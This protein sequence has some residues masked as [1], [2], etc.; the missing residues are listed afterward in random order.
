MPLSS[1]ILIGV[2]AVV[3]GVALYVATLQKKTAIIVI[4]FG[5]GVALLTLGVVALAVK[6]GM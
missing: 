1:G 4:G 2:L 5:A 3:V 6:S